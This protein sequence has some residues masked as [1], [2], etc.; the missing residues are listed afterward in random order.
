MVLSRHE[1]EA[2]PKIPLNPNYE[3]KGRYIKWRDWE[4]ASA[5]FYRFYGKGYY[6]NFRSKPWYLL[7]IDKNYYQS[8]KKRYSYRYHEKNVCFKTGL[9]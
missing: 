2:S 3:A 9:T 4:T 6:R 8:R 1:E 7:K 5:I